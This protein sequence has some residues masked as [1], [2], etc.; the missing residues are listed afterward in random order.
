MT[1]IRKQ[2]QVLQVDIWEERNIFGSHGQ[3][4]KEDYTRRFK[5]LKSKSRKPNGE[6]LEKVISCY[7][8][9]VNAHVDDDTLMRKCQIS[10]DFVDNLNNEYEHNSILDS[11]NGSGFVEELQQQQSILRDSIEQ[12]KT[13]ELLRG[14]LI[15][16]LREAL[17]EQEFK[18]EQVRSHIKEAHSRYKKA[19]DLCQKLGIPV[20]RQEPPNH[21]LKNSGLSETPGSFAPEPAN[22]SSFEKGQSSAV[23][24]SQENGREHEIPNGILS[25][26]ATRDNIEQ[27]IEEHSANKRLKLQND[28]YVSQ[29]QSPPPPPPPPPL[30]SDAF[31]QPPPPPEHPPPPESTSP[32]PPP[33]SDPP[34]VPPPPPTTG[35]FLPVPTAPFAGLPA[36]PM[37]AV[38]YNSYAVFSPLNYPMVSIP[39][40]FPNAPNTPPGFQGLAGPFY[41]PPFP[42]PPP[43]PPPPMNRK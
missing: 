38:P 41:G 31:Q 34:P 10:L 32:P 30:P 22:T 24:Y 33:T 13:S 35:S 29:P 3:S 39:P 15:S 6:L 2:C 23:M 7:K 14:N 26:Q 4:L 17:H 20:A 27:K 43:P 40:P 21:G 9:M 16:C 1:S 19:D 8:H 12:L 28:V 11:S 42:A 5:E 18:M 36:G 25:S 37:T